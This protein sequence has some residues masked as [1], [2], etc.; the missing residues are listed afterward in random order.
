MTSGRGG[1]QDRRSANQRAK[2]DEIVAAA[3]TVLL[4]RGMPACTVRS[5]ALEAGVAKGAVHYYFHDVDEI[6][7]LAM[8][9]ATEAWIAWLRASAGEPSTEPSTKTAARIFW[10]AVTACVEPFAQGDRTL[11]PL[12]LEYWAACTRA[13]RIE[14]LRVVFELLV[15]TVAELLGG[16]GADDPHGRA[17]AVSSY[18]FGAGMREALGRIEVT[19]LCRHVAALSGLPPPEDLDLRLPAGGAR[20]GTGARPAAG[21]GRGRA[22]QATGW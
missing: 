20:A 22:P 3:V 18:L 13:G 12:W 5:I 10:R 14:P 7:D 1:G 6:V 16:A 11:M 8:L 9:S 2:R 4:R 19:E 17:L 21:A 15:S